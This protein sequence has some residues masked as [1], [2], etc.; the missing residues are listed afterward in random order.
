MVDGTAALAHSAGGDSLAFKTTGTGAA[1]FALVIQI[2]TA[3]LLFGV[4]TGAA[5]VLNLVT[6]YCEAHD[7]TASWVIQGMHGLEI[8]LWA[9]DVV[10]FVLLVVVEV[11]KFCLKV[12]NERDG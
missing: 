9:A 4:I 12:W 5:I 11:R 7:L 1:A 6:K 2:G 3:V 10:C 8:L